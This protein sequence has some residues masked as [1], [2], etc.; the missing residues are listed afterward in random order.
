MRARAIPWRSCERTGRGSVAAR[1]AVL[2]DTSAAIAL[3]LEDHDAHAAMV[4][5]VRGRRLGPAGGAAHDALVGVAA[6]EHHQPLLTPAERARPT[7][8][9]LGVA[10]ATAA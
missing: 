3:V 9:A 4:A 1:P 10:L 5:A 8:R 7:Y 2:L 6:K